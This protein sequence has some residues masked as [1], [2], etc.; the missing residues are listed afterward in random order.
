MAFWLCVGLYIWC[1]H[2]Q[3]MAGNDTFLWRYK[4]ASE[5]RLQEAIIRKA[6]IQA[7]S[8]HKP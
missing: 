4:T 7:N 8:D 5:Q 6:E 3:Y 2:Q 1:E